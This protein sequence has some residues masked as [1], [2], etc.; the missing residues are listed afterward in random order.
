MALD[1]LAPSPKRSPRTRFHPA[2]IC[3]EAL[4]SRADARR[5]PCHGLS[6]L[7]AAGGR[8]LDPGDA[9]AELLKAGGVRRAIAHLR[10]RPDLRP[11]AIVPPRPTAPSRCAETTS[12]SRALHQCSGAIALITAASSA[13]PSLCHGRI[14]LAATVGRLLRPMNAQAEPLKAGRLRRTTAPRRHR[15]PTSGPEAIVPPP[16]CAACSQ[17]AKPPTRPQPVRDA[18]AWSLR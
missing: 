18:Q 7:A 6:C 4:V 8:L 10:H 11:G 12:R 17:H 1:R 3:S 15:R 13:R 14:R 2:G 9:R 5:L 16:S